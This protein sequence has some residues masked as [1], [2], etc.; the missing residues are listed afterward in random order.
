MPSAFET[1]LSIG[2]LV[3]RL[4]ADDS[5][6]AA[7]PPGLTR[8]FCCAPRHADV[9]IAARWADALTPPTG[10]PL[11]DSAGAWQ[12]ASVD[13]HYVV[14]CHSS[15][16]GPQ[17]YAIARFDSTFARGT[18]TFNARHWTD[19]APVFPL[20]YP[21]DEVLMVHLLSQGRGVEVH[22]CGIL[23]R[24]GR[25]YIFAGQSGAGKSTLARLW[26]NE[27]DITVL[28]DERVV[29]RTDRDPVVVYGT[30]WHGDAELAS[31]RSGPLAGLFFLRH[32]AAH[33]TSPLDPATAAA[34]LFSCAFLP[35][36]DRDAVSRTVDAIERIIGAAPTSVLAFTPTRSTIEY[37]TALNR[38]G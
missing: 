34:Q 28:S 25:A 23:D 14:T 38:S 12:L 4:T 33:A 17:P 30:P 32:G 7:P 10:T 2:D 1:C 31:P 21:L 24:T 11:F 22:G 37:I 13:R 15:L 16:K 18:V 20:E 3:V 8:A 29:V 36:Y 5:R 19:G 27:P 9:E 26:A 35:F 6:L